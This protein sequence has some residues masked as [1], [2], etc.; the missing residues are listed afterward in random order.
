MHLLFHVSCTQVCSV[1]RIGLNC[2]VL[3]CFLVLMLKVSKYFSFIVFF[4]VLFYLVLRFTRSIHLTFIMSLCSVLF[5]SLVLRCTVSIDLAL[6][7]SL[8][9]VLSCSQVYRVYTLGLNCIVCVLFYRA[10]RFTVSIHL[11]LIVSFVFCFI[12][13]SGLPCLYTWP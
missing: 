9:S 6:I 2:V 5:C 11:A 7:V 12:V 8:C 10:L 3:F 4:C 13:L 1:Y